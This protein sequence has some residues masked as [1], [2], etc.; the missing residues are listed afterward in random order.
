MCSGLEKRR[1]RGKF[2]LNTWNPWRHGWWCEN[3][4]WG[5]DHTCFI[6]P[7]L[8][9]RKYNSTEWLW[10][11]KNFLYSSPASYFSDS[12]STQ[13]VVR[14][15]SVSRWIHIFPV[16]RFFSHRFWSVLEMLHF[17]TA[18]W[19][20]VPDVLC[21]G[22][23]CWCQVLR[24]DYLLDCACL[25]C[26][27]SLEKYWTGA[28]GVIRWIAPLWNVSTSQLGCPTPLHWRWRFL[29]C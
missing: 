21:L 8:Y 5:L 20:H 15:S 11:M 14:K 23:L 24:G 12:E 28:Y 2:P 1:I 16:Y 13:K 26:N 7:A 19:S 22:A 4:G 29:V 27:W 3:N 18:L 25:S 6:N 10:Y 17:Q 9:F